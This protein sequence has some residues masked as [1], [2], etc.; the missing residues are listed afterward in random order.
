MRGTVGRTLQS[1]NITPS[2]VDVIK[3]ATGHW[4]IDNKKACNF[5]IFHRNSLKIHM[6]IKEKKRIS[7]IFSLFKMSIFKYSPIV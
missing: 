7:Q 2:D 3:C 5:V 6:L 1:G 4:C